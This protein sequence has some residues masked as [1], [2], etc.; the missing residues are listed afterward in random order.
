MIDGDLAKH[1]IRYVWLQ[2]FGGRKKD[3]GKNSKNACWKNLSFRNYADYMETDPFCD[4]IR[5]LTSLT[6]N[7]TLA[8]MCAEALYWRCHRSMIS[9]FLKSKGFEV[10]HNFR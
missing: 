9:D 6:E 5:E 4:G 10:V 8:I 3:F 7:G 2:K 1:K